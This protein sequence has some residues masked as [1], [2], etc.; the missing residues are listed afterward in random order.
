MKSKITVTPMHIE[1]LARGVAFLGSG[2]EGRCC[3]Y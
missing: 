2:G 3:I 1:H